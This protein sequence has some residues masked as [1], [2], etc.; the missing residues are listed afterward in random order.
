MLLAGA[1]A[2]VVVV[3]A[4]AGLVV[5]VCEG[6]SGGAFEGKAAPGASEAGLR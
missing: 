5:V 2:V 6:A 3:M 1:P 4:L